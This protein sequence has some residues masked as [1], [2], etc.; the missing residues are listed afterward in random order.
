MGLLAAVGALAVLS[1]IFN[2]GKDAGYRNGRNDERRY[3]DER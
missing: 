3:R 2:L 1:W